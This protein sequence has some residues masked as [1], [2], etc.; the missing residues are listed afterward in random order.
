MPTSD[1]DLVARARAG[2]ADAYAALLRRHHRALARVCARMLRDPVA[3][4]D[5]AQDAALVA[6]LQ[7][8]RLREPERFGAWLA[9]IGRMLWLRE[10]RRRGAGRERLTAT[11]SLPDAAQDERDD[12]PARIV[13]RERAADLAAAIAEL[14]AGQRDAV[15]L[16]HLADLP[17]SAVAR[18]LGT[19]PGAVRTRL[20]K[21]RLALRRRLITTTQED[22]MP[23][24]IADVVR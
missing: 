16:F 19:R 24:R 4:A 23:A 15:V 10:L 3:A 8:D 17:Q 12:P 21:A 11:G 7:L 13:A 20:H 2:D 6:W 1:P 9:G 22:P 18:R 5:V 14:P